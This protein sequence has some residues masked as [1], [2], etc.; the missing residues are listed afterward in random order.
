[1]KKLLPLVLVLLSIENLQAQWGREFS[2]GYTFANPMGAMKMNIN[3]GH[4]VVLD[5]HFVA[6]NNRYA[7]GTDLNYTVYGFDQSRQLYDFPD[8]T[9]AEM[10]VHVTNS[11]LNLM[12]SGRYNLIL[13]RALT[14][15]VGAK[16]GYGWYNTN[17]SIYDTN[18]FDSCEPVEKAILMKDGTLIFSIGGG[19]QYDVARF[20]KRLPENVFLVN[21]SSYYTQGGQVKYMNTDGPEHHVS[22]SSDRTGDVEATFINTQTQITHKHHVGNLYSSYARLMDFRLAFTFRT[23]R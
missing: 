4:G 14:P 17:L 13:N 12:A 20:F 3:R 5:Y 15:Y 8:G 19:V 9:T 2:I 6:P 10:D 21:I 7:I 23:S 16:A 1:M 22:S 11:F 18:D